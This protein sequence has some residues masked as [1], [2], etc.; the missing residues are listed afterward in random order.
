[1][2]PQFQWEKC[3]THFWPSMEDVNLSFSARTN[4]EFIRAD[5]D[6]FT[7]GTLSREGKKHCKTQYKINIFHIHTNKLQLA[8]GEPPA[9]ALYIYVCVMYDVIWC[10]LHSVWYLLCNTRMMSYSIYIYIYMCMCVCTILYHIVYKGERERDPKKD[11]NKVIHHYSSFFVWFGFDVSDLGGF[12]KVPKCGCQ[13]PP[14]M[15]SRIPP[16]FRPPPRDR[17]I[18]SKKWRNSPRNL[19]ISSEFIH[20]KV[21][22][23]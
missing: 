7:D 19:G 3:W 21:G 2:K 12:A 18:P 16:G 23:Q 13:P 22:T 1:M 17:W 15:T 6:T 5:I 8:S 20:E 10:I 9:S 11:R 4:S 14:L